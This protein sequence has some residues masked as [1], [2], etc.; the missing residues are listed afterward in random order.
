MPDTGFVP[1]SAFAMMS[2]ATVFTVMLAIGLAM[3]VRDLKWAASR[4]GL[5]A[6]SLLSV[7]VLVPIS[8]VLIGRA[9]GV[10]PEAEVGIA[11]LAISPGAPVA[12]RRSMDAGGHHSFAATLQLLI[13]SLAVL[14]MPLSVVA[15]NAIFGT[16]GEVSPA[17]VAKQV[18]IAQLIPLGLGLAVRRFAPGFASRIEPSFRRLGGVMLIAFLVVVLA[19]IWRLVFGAGLLVGLGAVA[20]TALALLTGHILGGPAAETRTAVAISSG[21]RNPGLALLVATSNQ[22][23][24]DVAATI[25]ACL[26]WAAATTT[27]Y[28]AWRR[29]SIQ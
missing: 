12:L 26:I 15:L 23:P 27:V 18:L 28:V 9:L 14:S 2:V 17:V 21:L 4:P 13:A 25:F 5:V 16:H 29:R 24:P 10:A 7:L 11:L 1:W 19:S 20:I 6:R 3:D 8:A 22:A